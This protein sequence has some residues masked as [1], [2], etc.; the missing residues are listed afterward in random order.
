MAMKRMFSLAVVGS[1]EFRELSH[2]AQ[3]AYYEIIGRADDDG[4]I[5]YARSILWRAGLDPAVLKQL[6]R[7]GFLI[8]FRGGIYLVR[9]WHAH[10]KIPESY[11]KPSRHTELLADYRV[12]NEGCYTPRGLNE[13]KAIRED[14]GTFELSVAEF[15]LKSGF[16][17]S[18]DAF[19]AYNEA[20]GWV[21]HG[22]ECVREHYV[23]Y[24]T[25]WENTYRLRNRLCALDVDDF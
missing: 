11:Y 9:H 20:R 5:S 22:G 3:L 17:S 6:T 1:D 12:D 10:N 21:G 18:P 16:L 13:Q 24:A 23:R 15:F 4:F 8:K 7:S 14:D 19:I 25:E 2:E